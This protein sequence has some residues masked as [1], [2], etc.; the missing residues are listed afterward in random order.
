MIHTTVALSSG[1]GVDDHALIH[2]G[3]AATIVA[4]LDDGRLR[5]KVNDEDRVPPRPRDRSDGSGG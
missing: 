4:L 2:A 5:V 3:S 1:V